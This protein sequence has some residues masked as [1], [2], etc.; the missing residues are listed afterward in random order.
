MPNLVEGLADVNE[1]R[2]AEAFVVRVVVDF[3]YY[4]MC[5]FNGSML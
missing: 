1:G 5:L 4:S 2:S 3:V